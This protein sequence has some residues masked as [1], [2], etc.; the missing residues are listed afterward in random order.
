LR[1]FIGDFGVVCCEMPK[2]FLFVLFYRMDLRLEELPFPIRFFAAFVLPSVG[3]TM[4]RMTV[5]LRR[6]ISVHEQVP[7]TN[8]KFFWH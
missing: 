6:G 2:Y 5:F 1:N 7:N 8:I 4:L 3:R